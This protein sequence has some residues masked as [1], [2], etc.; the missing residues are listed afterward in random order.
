MYSTSSTILGKPRL[1]MIGCGDV[2]LRLLPILVKTHKVYVLTTQE[3]KLALFRSLGACPFIGNLDDGKSLKKLAHLAPSVIHLAPPNQEG[4]NDLR[5]RNL[6]RTL[7]QGGLTKT[8]IYVST[9]GVY[10]DCKGDFVDE[11]RVVA[12][13]SPRGQR[14]HDAEQQL[15]SWAI[16][17]QVRVSILRVP[18]IY[19]DNRLPIE[20]LKAGTPALKPEEDVYTNHV[21]AD[22]LARMILLA[23]YRGLPQRV[24][25]ASDASWM[26]MG[27]YF[28]AVAK[29]FHLSPPKRVGFEEL[30]TQVSPQML[31]FMKESRRLR[32]YRLKEI[33][34]NFTY[35][36]VTDFLETQKSPQ[37]SLF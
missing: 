2:G 21:H 23:F 32:N 3:S 5:T 28:D 17:H 33:G 22:D 10:G 25:N 34:F 31:G 30:R 29:I 24:M 16:H 26:K 13:T 18:G 20:R 27:E 6:L 4:L 36:T 15:R 8:L 19:A 11:T 37:K 35:P 14:R 12:P 1:L 9:S 7:S